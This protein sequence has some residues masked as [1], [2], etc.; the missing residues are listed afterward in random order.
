MLPKNLRR[1]V[2]MVY[3][4]LAFLCFVSAAE[5]TDGMA[6]TEAKLAN[7][8]E[9]RLTGESLEGRKKGNC[10]KKHSQILTKS[11]LII[12]FWRWY[13]YD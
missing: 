9:W 12:F 1:L 8:R 4:I 3:W 2:D 7:G 11:H 5:T 13:I 10:K 6:E